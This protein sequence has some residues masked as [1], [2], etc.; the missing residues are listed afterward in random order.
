MTVKRDKVIKVIKI[1]AEQCNGC[2][3]CEAI[4]SAFHADPRYS[5]SNPA[6]ARI[7]VISDP[8]RNLYIP[9]FAGEYTA[10]ECMTRSK[11]VLGGV[12]FDEC[13]FC[14]AVCPSRQQFREPDTGL[15][16][17]CDGCESDPPLEEPMCV[18]WCITDALTYEE[19]VE[20]IE[21]E[22]PRAEDLE[23]ALDAL[24]DEYGLESVA[25]V[26]ARR[27]ANQEESLERR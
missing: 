10:S 23:T 8:L 11:Y 19:R 18:Q 24:I 15:P 20:K 12:E 26:L 5:S 16:L 17:K 6:K 7:R 9:V 27:L 4:C 3:A 21:D 25:E 2:R 22:E 13:A 14:R 1:D